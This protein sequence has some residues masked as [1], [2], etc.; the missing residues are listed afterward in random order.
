MGDPLRQIPPISID[1]QLWTVSELARFLG[2]H[3]K[4]V[5]SWV[6]QGLVP[7]YKIGGRVRFD[8]AEVAQWLSAQ[9]G[10]L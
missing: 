2:L 10:G 9:R 6:E 8:P 5:Y 1:D 4:T 7:H 3:T